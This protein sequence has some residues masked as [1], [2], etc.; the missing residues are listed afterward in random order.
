MWQSIFKVLFKMGNKWVWF[1][2]IYEKKLIVREMIFHYFSWM[3]AVCYLYKQRHRESTLL[4]ILNIFSYIYIC[5]PRYTYII[6][7]IHQQFLYHKSQLAL[8]SYPRKRSH[9]NHHIH[10]Y[11]LNSFPSV[12]KISYESTMHPLYFMTPIKF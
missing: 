1:L 12:I 8:Y 7:N 10:G 4:H 2:S 11:I 9:K 6:T 5:R 3:Y